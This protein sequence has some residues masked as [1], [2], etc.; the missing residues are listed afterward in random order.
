[1]SMS[2]M[3]NYNLSSHHYQNKVKAGINIFQEISNDFNNNGGVKFQN[4]V[5]PFKLLENGKNNNFISSSPSN[6]NTMDLETRRIIEREMNPYIL[7]MKNELKLIVENYKKEMEEN[8]NIVYDIKE[9]REEANQN[10][11]YNENRYA[12]LA[13]KINEIQYTLTGQKNDI[14]NCQ[15]NTTYVHKRIQLIQENMEKL[16]NDFDRN[17]KSFINDFKES[18]HKDLNENIEK[19]TSYKLLNFEKNL[20]L[21]KEENAYFKKEMNNVNTTLTLLNGENDKKNEILNDI[22]SKYN[23]VMNK[24]ENLFLNNKKNL[25]IFN[26]FEIRNNEFQQKIKTLSDKIS[27]INNNL[28][29]N[30]TDI[31]TNQENI[32]TLNQ[33]I[34]EIINQ[35]D[36]FKSERQIFDNKI[37][38]INVKLDSQ[39][40]KISK[41]YSELTD[42]IDL[43]NNNLYNDLIS[44]ISKTKDTLDNIKDYYDGAILNV[45]KDMDEFKLIIK[46][47]PFLNMN[48]NEK[49]SVLFKQEQ[50]KLNE[51]FKEQIKL[52]I[53]ELD[54]VKQINPI[55]KS[56]FKTIE[57]NFQK[58]DKRFEAKTKEINLLEQSMK[59]CTDL[60][61]K[62]TADKISKKKDNSP[63]IGAIQPSL[64][65]SLKVEEIEMDIQKLQKNISD[66]KQEIINLKENIAKINEKSIPEIYKC[67]SDKLNEKQIIYNSNINT[68]PKINM[69]SNKKK[70]IEYNDNF[71]YFND[72]NKPDNAKIINI[73]NNDNKNSPKIK[74]KDNNNN[75]ILNNNINFDDL[76][77]QIES[78]GVGG[79]NMNEFD[80][81]NNNNI[82]NI[83][84][85]NKSNKSKGKNDINSFDDSFSLNKSDLKKIDSDLL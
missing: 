54:K 16:K 85:E 43:N 66:N 75:V 53:Q 49:L 64:I 14:N 58:I 27:I 33:K 68:N 78:L 26:N 67:I 10:K 80:T 34:I 76:A 83:N 13:T 41:N 59:I 84:S 74:Y 23:D 70:E 20:D 55:D 37:V 24:I 48:E 81:N 65:S 63:I 1:M 52:L 4:Y 21:I 38:E 42:K 30:Y 22:N 11:E 18:L 39:S 17:E 32:N 56:I 51:I 6:I 72:N 45:Q 82:E 62:L 35:M 69:N 79:N 5:D 47:N 77:G 12:N 29:T 57:N 73:I 60:I 71:N 3:S 19:I 44:Q 2:N 46:K 36:K 61:Q 40:E 7:Q 28:N 9:L 31:K 8:V 50:I 15:A 25:S